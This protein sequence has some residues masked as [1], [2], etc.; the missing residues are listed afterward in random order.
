MQNRDTI[1]RIILSSI[2]L[3]FII[4]LNLSARTKLTTLPDRSSIRIDLK[5]NNFTLI[6]EERTINL[7]KGSNHIEFA[8]ANTY[9]DMSSI[10]S[11]QFI[12]PGLLT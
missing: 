4:D 2:L 11:D 12:P 3:F 6:E 8:W 9:I 7:Q 5:N 10:N 1:K